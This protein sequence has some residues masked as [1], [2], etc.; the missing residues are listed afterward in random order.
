MPY[1]RPELPPFNFYIHPFA[2]CFTTPIP[3]AEFFRY[4]DQTPMVVQ[5]AKTSLSISL[6]F[7]LQMNLWSWF[8]FW[9]QGRKSEGRLRYS[10]GDAPRS[11]VFW[12]ERVIRK[13]D[14]EKA[15]KCYD[16]TFGP[17][18]ENDRLVRLRETSWNST[19]NIRKWCRMIQNVEFR[20]WSRE[21]LGVIR[22]RRRYQSA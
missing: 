9:F 3:S 17:V 21:W 19:L 13:S 11:R 14:R 10:W 8:I 16:E 7:R 6:C 4:H 5:L 15:W 2:F 18:W 1:D 22:K 12:V 20:R